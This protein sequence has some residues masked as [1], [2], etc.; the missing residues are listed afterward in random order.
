M[1]K[2]QMNAR[3]E[4]LEKLYVA[5]QTACRQANAALVRAGN[6]VV[7]LTRELAYAR[8]PWWRRWWRRVCKGN[9]P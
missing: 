9:K 3:L 1:N 2:Q 8:L 6:E 7:R 4:T 5:K